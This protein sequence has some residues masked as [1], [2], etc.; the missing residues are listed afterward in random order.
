MADSCDDV[1]PMS[2][3]ATTNPEVTQ[4]DETLPFTG[5]ES[6]PVV[7][8]APVVVAGGAL[9]LVSTRSVRAETDE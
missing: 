9:T 5:A 6:G 4:T 7:A 8:L 2:I 3:T 1:S